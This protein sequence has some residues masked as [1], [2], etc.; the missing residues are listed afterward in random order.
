MHPSG[1]FLL[2][3]FSEKLRIMNILIDDI[4]TSKEFMIRGCREVWYIHVFVITN[5]HISYFLYIQCSFSNGGHL[6]AAANANLIQ[7]YSTFSYENTANLKGHNG[8]VV[9]VFHYNLCMYI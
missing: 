8:K 7:I 6:F 5:A 4:R 1:L 9:H 2:V 3:G